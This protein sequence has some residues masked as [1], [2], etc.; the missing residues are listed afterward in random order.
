MASWGLEPKCSSG[1]SAPKGLVPNRG[2]SRPH[3][4]Q[5]RGRNPWGRVAQG[6][7][8]AKVPPNPSGCPKAARHHF[9]CMPQRGPP[10]KAK[11]APVAQGPGGGGLAGRPSPQVHGWPNAL[12]LCQGPCCGLGFGATG[13]G[14]GPLLL[15]QAASPFAPCSPLGLAGGRHLSSARDN[16]PFWVAGAGLAS[17][18]TGHP[19]M[20]TLGPMG[21]H[22]PR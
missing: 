6:V 14:L 17:L 1:H 22:H 15:S 13:L 4:K 8:W 10:T 19:P 12:A 9:V 5:S 3:S 11:V 21:P 20:P 7:V 2:G 18:V 16:S